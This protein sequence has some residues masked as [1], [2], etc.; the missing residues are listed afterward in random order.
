[1]EPSTQLILQVQKQYQNIAL[2][3]VTNSIEFYSEPCIVQNKL[4]GK[5]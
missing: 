2:K 5:M 4:R 1:M 3:L